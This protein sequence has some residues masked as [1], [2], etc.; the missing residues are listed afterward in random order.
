[1]I[2]DACWIKVNTRVLR[3][4]LIS[5]WLVSNRVLMCI[6]VVLKR[7]RCS[8]FWYEKKKENRNWHNGDIYDIEYLEL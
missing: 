7:I 5:Y 6:S 2:S 8:V 1:M 4:E 3:C